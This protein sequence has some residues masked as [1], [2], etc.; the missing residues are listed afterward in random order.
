MSSG[1]KEKRIR[2]RTE[3]CLTARFEGAATKH[4]VRITDLSEGGCYVDSIAEV[5]AGETLSLKISSGDGWVQLQGVVAHH[6]PRLGFGVRFINL[7]ARQR[8]WIDSVLHPR[9][10]RAMEADEPS[11]EG[12]VWPSSDQIDFIDRRVM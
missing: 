10:A 6:F 12:D 8:A 11:E 7:N 1:S 3:V 9:P 4:D 5:M 2:P